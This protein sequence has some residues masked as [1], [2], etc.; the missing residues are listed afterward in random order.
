MDFGATSGGIFENLGEAWANVVNEYPAL[1][2]VW[3]LWIP[4]VLALAIYAGFAVS[5]YNRRVREQKETEWQIFEIEPKTTQGDPMAN[6]GG[7]EILMSTLGVYCRGEKRIR[8]SIWAKG[9]RVRFLVWLDKKADTRGLEDTITTAL[10]GTE[11]RRLTEDEE[12]A[13]MAER[14]KTYEVVSAVQG[15]PN[16]SAFGAIRTAPD[17]AEI[18]G[19]D[20]MLP[21]INTLCSLKGEDEAGVDLV[22][23]APRRNWKKEGDKYVQSIRDDKPNPR[24]M[25]L[26]QGVSYIK[27]ISW[28]LGNAVS[29]SIYYVLGHILFFAS[30]AIDTK[31]GLP[32]ASKGPN[33]VMSPV[34]EEEMKAVY[35]KFSYPYYSA[36]IFLYSHTDHDYQIIRQLETAMTAYNKPRGSS[37]SFRPI[38]KEEEF[39]KGLL[40]PM[41]DLFL[42]NSQEVANLFHMPPALFLTASEKFKTTETRKAAGTRLFV[43]R[44]ENTEK[45]IPMGYVM[46]GDHRKLVYL[47]EADLLRHLYLLGGS[48]TGKSTLVEHIS[49][50]LINQTD[51]G[52]ILMDPAEDLFRAVLDMAYTSDRLKDVI[53]IAPHYVMKADKK[54]RLRLV[55]LN[56]LDNSGDTGLEE[57]QKSKV[58]SQR[59]A[60]ISEIFEAVHGWGEQATRATKVFSDIMRLFEEVEDPHLTVLEASHFLSNKSVRTNVGALAG[61]SVEAERL[62]YYFFRN[63]EQL[64]PDR[65][66]E[67]AGP[68]INRLEL[69]LNNPDLMYTLGQGT[70]SF[71]FKK[72]MNDGK[73]ILCCLSLTGLGAEGAKTLGRI[74]TNM[75]YQ[76]AISRVEERERPF[77]VIMD[78]FQNFC[79]LDQAKA[80]SMIRKFNVAY[81]MAHQYLSQPEEVAKGKQIIDAV[82]SNCANKVIGRISSRD[83]QYIAKELEAPDDEKEAVL[84]MKDYVNL[85][86]YQFHGRFIIKGAPQDPVTFNIL[87]PMEWPVARGVL[88]DKEFLDALDMDELVKDSKNRRQAMSVVE[89][90]DQIPSMK[91]IGKTYEAALDEI[92][93]RWGTIDALDGTASL[94]KRYMEVIEARTRAESK[95]VEAIHKAQIAKEAA[96]K[97]K[98]KGHP[99]EESM[100]DAQMAVTPNGIA[101]HLYNAKYA[102]I[103]DLKEFYNVGATT[104][105]GAL[106]S[107]MNDGLIERKGEDNPGKKKVA[108]YYLTMKAA[109][110]VK[111][112]TGAEDTAAIRKRLKNIVDAPG[113]GYYSHARGI[114]EIIKTFQKTGNQGGRNI[115]VDKFEIEGRTVFL[116]QDEERDR[117]VQL[118]P[119][120]YARIAAARPGEHNSVVVHGLFEYDRGSEREGYLTQ[121]LENYLIYYE[122]R[123]WKL[124][125]DLLDSMPRTFIITEEKKGGESRMES[126][127]ALVRQIMQDR[128]TWDVPIYINTMK[129]FRERPLTGWRKIDGPYDEL[130]NIF[131]ESA[132]ECEESDWMNGLTPS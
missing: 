5:R 42:L 35:A 104:I 72:A 131:G 77:F 115:V 130:Y 87:P 103:V 28:V 120:A 100:L 60:A 4:V 116:Y 81:I 91:R 114:N 23:G 6:A 124:G 3:Y 94:K 122:N 127:Q 26:I 64:K 7:M 111:K 113:Q 50:Y 71:D 32:E 84:R 85:P 125:R 90:L 41:F 132:N 121:K 15:D 52:F 106:K 59:V 75:V 46:D 95:A 105:K 68:I 12:R 2:Y 39:K 69:F 118:A 61:E 14:D 129:H 49:Q 8:L 29:Q 126:I 83:T 21:I 65:R 98:A 86:D 33:P 45:M 101:M 20:I 44:E 63:F 25:R 57:Q 102:T 78:E 76:A 54:K 34:Q 36:K 9:R 119:D 108:L 96:R 47:T 70:N 93:D 16:E 80:L 31:S 19:S 38:K 24:K 18:K 128:D 55:G 66:H 13:L 37:F 112:E 58:R 79:S 30:P 97:K 17:V 22:L 109:A 1:G 107:L 88:D 89:I 10:T 56:P 48:G 82:F 51:N 11:A 117:A 99:I 53:V 74:I 92:V 43:D 40:S 67:V 123:N 110:L 27:Q 62:R 73:I